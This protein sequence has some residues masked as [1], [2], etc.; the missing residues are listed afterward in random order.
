MKGVAVAAH[1]FIMQRCACRKFSD[2]LKTWLPSLTDSHSSVK[3]YRTWVCS[4]HEGDVKRDLK[5]NSSSIRNAFFTDIHASWASLQDYTISV[6]RHH[7]L[8]SADISWRYHHL[9][10]CIVTSVRSWAEW[11]ETPLT[12]ILQSPH[13]SSFVSVKTAVCRLWRYNGHKIDLI[14]HGGCTPS[15]RPS[16]SSSWTVPT[17][18]TMLVVKVRI[19]HN[20]CSIYC[21]TVPP[22]WSEPPTARFLHH[23]PSLLLKDRSS[24]CLCFDH[25]SYQYMSVKSDKSLST[26]MNPITLP[27]GSTPNLVKAYL[28]HLSL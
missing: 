18:I 15:Q 12:S 20:L 23:P 11:Q 8:L 3:W 25:Y 19:L 7:L 28:L 10:D 14:T 21:E 4:W 9:A 16:Q 17:T 26:S 6:L 24:S 22:S 27:C 1:N 2:F 5:H 13:T